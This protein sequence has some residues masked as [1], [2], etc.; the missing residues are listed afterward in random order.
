MQASS[1]KGYK[2]SAGLSTGISQS[3]LLVLPNK[4]LVN[5]KKNF[6]TNLNVKY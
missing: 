3:Q 2:W 4:L 6:L 5:F 1:A